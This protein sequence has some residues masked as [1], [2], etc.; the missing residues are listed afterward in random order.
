MYDI[1]VIVPV[2]NVRDYLQ[3]CL[4]SVIKALRC[5][6]GEVIL[7]NDGSTDDSLNI[8]Y[9]YKDKLPNLTI[10]NQPNQGLGEARNSGMQCASGKYIYFLDSDDWIDSTAFSVLME[11]AEQNACDIVQGGY[12]YAFPDGRIIDSSVCTLES[13]MLISRGEAMHK[14]VQGN[15]IQNFAWGKLYRRKLLSDLKFPKKYFEDSFW[16][17]RV[18]DKVINYAI[19]NKR[20][21]YYRQRSSSISGN[22]SQRNFD[23]IEGNLKR[24]EFLKVEYP[25]LVDEAKRGIENTFWQFYA[26]CLT[27]KPLR[28]K[29]I[30]IISN[31]ICNEAAGGKTKILKL[32]RTAFVISDF[33]LRAKGKL[34]SIKDGI[35]NPKV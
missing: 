18:L 1:S 32:G 16:Q 12:C 30:E 27:N 34:M 3:Q 35:V 20:L 33:V 13:S 21:Y 10:I 24:L 9:E 19:V 4:D 2:Y 5:I 28:L 29:L 17:Y 23:L 31:Y 26:C 15:E 6:N 14:L 22:F 25:Y 8:C 11:F 7:V